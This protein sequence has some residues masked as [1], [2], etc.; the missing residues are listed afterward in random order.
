M[1]Q[2]RLIYLHVW[3]WAW[4]W[5][6]VSCQR[7]RATSGKDR[8]V[9]VENA[10][11]HLACNA[12]QNLHVYVRGVATHS[13]ND[14]VCISRGFAWRCETRKQ[15]IYLQMAA[16]TVERILFPISFAEVVAVILVEIPPPQRSGSFENDRW[17]RDQT[18]VCSNGLCGYINH[19]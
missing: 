18:C 19:K 11:S 15:T 14:G 3:S 1:D 10:A 4:T 12:L 9:G 8:R 17:N 6:K 5:V 16:D 7:R 13:W 2:P